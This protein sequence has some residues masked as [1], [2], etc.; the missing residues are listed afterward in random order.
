VLQT[1]P[2]LVHTLSVD[3][4]LTSIDNAAGELQNY[5]H[6]CLNRKSSGGV[7]SA[8]DNLLN[9]VVWFT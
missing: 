4:R 1:A 5:M 2:R 3:W 7:I 6:L 9:D 8:T